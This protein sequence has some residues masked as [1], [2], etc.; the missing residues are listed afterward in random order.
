M[1]DFSLTILN[2]SDGI[3]SPAFITAI[4]FPLL[5]QLLVYQYIWKPQKKIDIKKE[6]YDAA[7]LALSH[8]A[9]DAL[10]TTLQNQKSDSA[11]RL[12]PQLRDETKVLIE[13]SQLLVSSFFTEEASHLFEKAIGE[14]ISIENVPNTEFWGSAGKAVRALKDEVG[15]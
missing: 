6:A 15:L 10:D 8:Y 13:K 1:L 5:L 2:G 14:E 11:L 3:A 4:V 12:K 9:S 7:V